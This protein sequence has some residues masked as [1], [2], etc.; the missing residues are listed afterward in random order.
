[1]GFFYQEDR[2]LIWNHS[3]CLICTTVQKK[4]KKKERKEPYYCF[5]MLVPV[6]LSLFHVYYILVDD[7]GNVITGLVN[8]V[9]KQLGRTFTNGGSK[10]F[11]LGIRTTVLM[12]LA[13]FLIFRTIIT[14][15]LWVHCRQKSGLILPPCLPSFFP[16]FLAGYCNK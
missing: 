8:V 16:S 4:N 1:M 10:R 6:C 15:S 11:F 14:K 2:C 5:K 7:F 9:L 3:I 12:W 13:F